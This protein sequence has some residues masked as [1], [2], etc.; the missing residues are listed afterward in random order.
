MPIFDET[1][2]ELREAKVANPTGSTP[3]NGGLESYG[4]SLVAGPSSPLINHKANISGSNIAGTRS[5][6]DRIGN[7]VPMYPYDHEGEGDALFSL[8]P[9]QKG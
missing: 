5:T 4:D 1:L 9:K 3:S 6:P 7:D 2:E 8:T